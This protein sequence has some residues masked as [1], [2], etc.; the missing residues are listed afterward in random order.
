[1]NVADARA[2]MYARFSSD[3]QS[4]RSIEDQLALCRAFCERE[5]LRVVVMTTK[6]FPAHQL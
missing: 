6:P 1:M 5:G 3:K 2:A 4:V